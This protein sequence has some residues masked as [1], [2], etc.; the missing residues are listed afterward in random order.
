MAKGTLDAIGEQTFTDGRVRKA[1][2]TIMHDPPRPL[3]NIVKKGMG[4]LSISPQKVRESLAR[5]WGLRPIPGGA[6]DGG[7]T[8]AG[9]KEP[10]SRRATGRQATYD[11]NHHL[12]GKPQEVLELYRAVDRLCF[13]MKQEAVQRHFKA[14][15]ISYA[16]QKRIFCSVHLL[17]SGL[18]IWLHLK[19][20]HLQNP[21]SFARDVSNVGHWGG[22]DL[23]L[24][25]SSISQLEE[26]A[27]LIRMSAESRT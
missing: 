1:L 2:E 9:R 23:E 6:G 21:P 8:G 3:L 12:G 16:L 13:S 18:R 7:S 14:K 10:P 24:D 4:D 20:R 5:V 26:A 11:E 22:G 27:P 17:Q 25:I 15:Y 19:Y